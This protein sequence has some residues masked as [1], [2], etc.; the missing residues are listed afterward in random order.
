MK[1]Q[2]E[3]SHYFKKNYDSKTRFIS[4]WHQINEITEINP[5]TILEIGIDNRSVSQYLK[6]RNFN[7]TTLDI[8]LSG[9][10]ENIHLMENIIGKSGN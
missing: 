8:F 7:V 6:E 4:Y 9:K 5:N 10:K 1:P 2:V 3:P